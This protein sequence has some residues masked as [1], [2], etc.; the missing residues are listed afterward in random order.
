MRM[1]CW[2]EIAQ[3]CQLIDI[4]NEGRGGGGLVGGT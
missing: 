3:S 2:S 1:T 4:D